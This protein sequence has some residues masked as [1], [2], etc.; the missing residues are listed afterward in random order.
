MSNL[1]I[2]LENLS[3]TGQNC[4]KILDRI[5]LK[6]YKKRTLGLIGPT[7]SG[8]TSL[9]RLINMIDHPSSGN[10]YYKD[11]NIID[12]ENLLNI[13]R[14]IT[15]VF[16]K[17]IV[18]KGTVFD[19]VYYGLNLR[20]KEKEESKRNILKILKDV[21]LKGYQDQDASILSCGEIQ[22]VALARALIIKPEI[23]LLDEPTANLDPNSTEKIEKVIE[24]IQKNMD[25]AIVMSTHNLIQGQRLCDEIAILNKKIFQI[26]K[27]EEI[28]RKPKNKF[29]ANFVGMKNIVE[30]IAT[31]KS[32]SLT[33]INVKDLIIMSSNHL[34]IEN[35]YVSIRPEDITVTRIKVNHAELNQFTGKI[36]SYKENGA[37]IELKLNVNDIYFII[38]LT[39]KNFFDLELDINS[40]VWIQF[41]FSSVHIFNKM[42]INPV[43][44]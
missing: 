1:L 22:R 9:L 27:S 29:V 30:G 35:V 11:T 42:D 5:N 23:L 21:G 26:G 4:E 34:D 6:I 38:Y 7:G 2:E 33:L 36:I 43:S 25:I 16:Q 13:K 24:N 14:K 8:K 31:K 44:Y 18:F 10:I 19:N 39:R 3:K 20:N 17:P 28:F 15:M 41:N 40:K 12:L 32:E 37:L